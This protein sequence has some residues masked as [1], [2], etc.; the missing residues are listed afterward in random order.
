VNIESMPGVGT[1]VTVELPSRV[2]ASGI[3]EVRW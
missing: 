3:T 2:G 1:A